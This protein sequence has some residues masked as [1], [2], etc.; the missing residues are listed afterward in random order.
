MLCRVQNCRFPSTHVT[1]GHQCGTCGQMGHGQ[2]ECNDQEAIRRLALF[3]DVL[4]PDERCAVAGC[5]TSQTHKTVA[6]HCKQCGGCGGRHLPLC[7]LATSCP[8]PICRAGNPPDLWQTVY[9]NTVCAVCFESKP[10]LIL[11]NCRHAV[12]CK[13]CYHQIAFDSI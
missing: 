13:D 8:C 2:I 4:P 12:V 11:P 5:Q 10:L 7:S 3:L 1:L 9:T 6:H